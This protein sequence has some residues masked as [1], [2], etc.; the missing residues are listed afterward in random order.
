MRVNP[1]NRIYNMSMSSDYYSD[2]HKNYKQKQKIQ[3]KVS[4]LESA[5]KIKLAIIKSKCIEDRYQESCHDLWCEIDEI[6]DTIIE[7]NHEVCKFDD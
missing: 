1:M 7:L 2:K 4:K 5:F 3:N 6:A